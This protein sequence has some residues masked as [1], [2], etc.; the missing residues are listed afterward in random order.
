MSVASNQ[1]D[2]S[3]K[4]NHNS[5]REVE[6]N[7]ITNKLTAIFTL[8]LTSSICASKST[9]SKTTAS[10]TYSRCRIVEEYIVILVHSN[11][12]HNNED[13]KNTL[14]QL[15]SVVNEANQCT[16]EQ[17]C[18]GELNESDDQTAFI[19][20]SSALAQHLVPRIHEKPKLDSIYIYCDDKAKH[21]A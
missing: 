6:G 17:Q 10:V 19:I 2:E 1:R 12:D 21:Q 20:Y 13:F 11:T 8:Y 3:P 16:T 18:I 4:I 14:E 5:Y 7:R 15:R 9:T